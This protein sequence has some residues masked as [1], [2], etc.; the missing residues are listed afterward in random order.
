MTGVAFNNG[1]VLLDPTLPV[2][3]LHVNVQT[4]SLGLGRTFGLYG[5]TAQVFAALPFSWAH[6]EGKVNGQYQN[7]SRTGFSDAR[8]RLSVLLKGAPALEVPEFAKRATI[9]QKRETIIG[10]SLSINV[11]IGQYN[12]T[13]LI[14]LGMN[15]FSFKPELAVSH[16][17]A[18][19]WL[20]DVYAGVWLFTN[21]NQY[22][23]GGSQRA[24]KPMGTVQFHLSYNLSLKAWV[25]VNATFYA[26]GNTSLDGVP[27]SDRQN[28]LRLGGTI[29]FPTG[30]FSSIKIAGSS[31]AI[32]AFGADFTTISIGWQRSFLPKPKTKPAKRQ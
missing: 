3:D 27:N 16:P 4:A 31:G 10:T 29:V 22:Y 9:L 14:N 6:A 20:M 19:R 11:P 12:K 1:N 26:G 5:K 2:K 25:A 13:K 7:T 21:N 32:V 18:K 23:P 15:R 17:I 8:L 30:K 28:N 24:Q